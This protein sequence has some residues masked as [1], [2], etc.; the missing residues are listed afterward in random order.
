MEESLDLKLRAL[1]GVLEALDSAV[2][3]YS[4]GVDSTLLALLSYRSLGDRML[5]VNFS[6]PLT[7]PRERERAKTLAEGLGFPLRVVKTDELGLPGFAENPRDRCYRCKKHRVALLRNLARE[8]GFQAL[9]DGS[10]LDDATAYRPGRKALEEEGGLSPLE[11]AGLRKADVRALARELGLP[12]WDAPPRPC[13]ATRFPYGTR[14]D[15][16]WLRRVDAAEAELEALGMRVFRV[17]TDA[18]HHARIEL[19]REEMAAFRRKDTR[20]RL[21]KKLMGLG[22]TD[23]ELDLDGFRS[24]SRDEEGLAGRR[25]VLH[26]GEERTAD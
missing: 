2:V 22:F 6:S 20:L 11:E 19:G 9:L 14:M 16:E 8:L 13:L 3:A 10:N 25:L 21:V 4:G 15:R 17:R 24:G 7:P 23:L 1:R 12:N 18:P 5:A 26:A